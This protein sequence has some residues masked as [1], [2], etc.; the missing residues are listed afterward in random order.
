MRKCYYIIIF[1][2]NQNHLNKSDALDVYKKREV[3]KKEILKN[4]KKAKNKK[5]KRILSEIEE[6]KN[7]SWNDAENLVL[8]GCSISSSNITE[9]L[10][11][12]V[13][14]KE[15]NIPGWQLFGSVLPWQSF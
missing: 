8:H 3:T 13:V 9:L 6:Q 4:F 11:S 14:K 1:L 7:I 2:V 15:R 12:A 10:R 5:M